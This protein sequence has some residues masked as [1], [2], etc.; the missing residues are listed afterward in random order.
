MHELAITKEL[1]KSVLQFAE[2]A[3]AQKVVAVHL[4]IGE[5]YGVVEDLLTKAFHHFS[6]DTICA[7]ARLDIL[8]KPICVKCT[9]CD[10]VYYL[11]TSA[12]SDMTCPQCGCHNS[13]ILS[14][15]EFCI[16]NLEIV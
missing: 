11:K 9:G 4:S 14:G 12:L 1:I 15:D 2:E 5:T 10:S 7:D 8:F 3:R 6:R 13:Q 16:D